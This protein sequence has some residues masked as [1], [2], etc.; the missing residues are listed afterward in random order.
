MKKSLISLAVGT[1]VGLAMGTSAI[2]APIYLDNGVD[3]NVPFASIFG[4]GSTKTG[5]F[6]ELGYTGTRA[7]SVYL[8]DPTVAGTRV[9]DTNINSVMTAYGFTS[10]VTTNAGGGTLTNATGPYMSEYPVDPGGL[11]INAL[12]APPTI[13]DYNGFTSG[14]GF[15]AYGQFGHW[16]LTYQYS[17]GGYTRPAQGDVQFDGGYFDVFYASGTGGANNGKQLLRLNLTDSS[18]QG[19]NLKLSG[20]VSFDFDGN[21]SNDASGDT[22]VQNFFNIAQSGQSFYSAWLANPA[23]GIKW[24][25]NTNVNPPF[26]TAAELFNGNV[27]LDPSTPLDQFALMRQANLNGEIRFETPEPGSLALLGVA[28]AGMG[29]VQLR[30]R[31][32]KK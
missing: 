6:G 1:V 17:I 20:V 28:L 30:K 7:T 32:I 24:Q 9:I 23:A 12:N 25:I 18:F 3:Q 15:P 21:G 5:A 11:N 27:D 2:A 13:T 4:N 14:E 16:G 26:P 31:S 22:F 10:G 8:G 29:L 19:V